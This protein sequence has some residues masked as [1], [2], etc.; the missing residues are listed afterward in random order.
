MERAA[1]LSSLCRGR[2]AAERGHA[3]MAR[4]DLSEAEIR[5]LIESLEH[6]LAT[7]HTKSHPETGP[8]TEC[9]AAR[10]LRDKLVQLLGG[11]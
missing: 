7:C 6:C 9:D 5:M 4:Y 3:E 10:T 11:K 8:C 2:N 1:V